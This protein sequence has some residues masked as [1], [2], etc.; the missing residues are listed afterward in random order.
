MSP[1]YQF[2]D[3]LSYLID[4]YGSFKHLDCDDG[5]CAFRIFGDYVIAIHK[6]GD[7]VVVT[8]IYL[9]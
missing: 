7:K 2:S 1:S 8:Y 3:K 4:T 9:R 5:F 6:V